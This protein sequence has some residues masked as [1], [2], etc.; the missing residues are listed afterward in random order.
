ML[1]PVL[2]IS[3]LD[4]YAVI[5]GTRAIFR[6]IVGLLPEITSGSQMQ[7]V[8]SIITSLIS[9]HGCAKDTIPTAL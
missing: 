1:L 7:N 6:A 2:I 8:L 3:F 9:L 4:R 5:F